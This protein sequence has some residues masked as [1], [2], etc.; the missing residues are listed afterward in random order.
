MGTQNELQPLADCERKGKGEENEWRS[1]VPASAGTHAPHCGPRT[2][3]EGEPEPFGAQDV[4]QLDVSQTRLY[5]NIEILGGRVYIRATSDMI[6]RIA[7]VSQIGT[8]VNKA[9]SVAMIFSKL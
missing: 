1:A 2:R 7:T 9:T 5:P 6:M 8:L 4:V 3:I